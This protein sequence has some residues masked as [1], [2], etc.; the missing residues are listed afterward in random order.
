[1]DDD[2]DDGSGF[3]SEYEDGF[4][5]KYKIPTVVDQRPKKEE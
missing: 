3:S 2:P 1:M 5:K 4:Q